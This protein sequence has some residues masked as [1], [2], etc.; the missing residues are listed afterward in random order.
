MLFP[1]P[2]G[3]RTTNCFAFVIISRISASFSEVLALR[4]LVSSGSPSMYSKHSLDFGS[5]TGE[6]SIIDSWDAMM[7]PH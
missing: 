4:V 7:G 6:G 2:V 5:D 3:P 1:H